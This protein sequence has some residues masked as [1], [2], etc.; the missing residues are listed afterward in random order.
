MVVRHLATTLFE[1]EQYFMQVDSHCLF[2]R[3]WDVR[4]ID[5]LN[6]ITDTERVL[7]SHHPPAADTVNRFEGQGINICK[8]QWDGNVRV[9]WWKNASLSLSLSLA[10][11]LTV[12]IGAAPL[13]GASGGAGGRQAVPRRVC[14]RRHGVCA[15][16]DPHRLPVGQESAVPLQRKRNAGD[17]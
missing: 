17:T 4:I 7:L 16:G 14:G 13:L 8:Y 1:G 10:V 11:R 6:K 2:A 12:R 5:D 3:N 15:L 9:W